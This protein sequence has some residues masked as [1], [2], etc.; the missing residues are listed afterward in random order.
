MQLWHVSDWFVERGPYFSME[1]MAHFHRW[2]G[3]FLLHSLKKCT[4]LVQGRKIE[5]MYIF[6]YT[7]TIE[8]LTSQWRWQRTLSQQMWLSTL[9]FGSVTTHR[10]P[11][12]EMFVVPGHQ[13]VS[14]PTCLPSVS[15]SIAMH[16]KRS[17]AFGGLQQRQPF[18]RAPLLSNHRCQQGTT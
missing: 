2:S 13:K 11:R 5:L 1:T 14:A 3:N 6:Y 10:T 17:T 8:A 9:V 16:L 7:E 4:P 12:V 15:T 18:R